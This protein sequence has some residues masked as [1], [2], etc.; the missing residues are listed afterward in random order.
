ME[1]KH[2]F[3]VFENKILGKMFGPIAKHVT[4]GFIVCKKPIIMWRSGLGEFNLAGRVKKCYFN[5]IP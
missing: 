5:V 3:R 1:K 4:D 2:R